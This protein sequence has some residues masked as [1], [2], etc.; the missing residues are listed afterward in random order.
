MGRGGIEK[1][2]K[3]LTDYLPATFTHPD[4]TMEDSNM[5]SFLCGVLQV[6]LEF[7]NSSGPFKEYAP[8]FMK[9]YRCVQDE[10]AYMLSETVSLLNHIRS[11]QYLPNINTIEKMDELQKLNTDLIEILDGYFSTN[12]WRLDTLEN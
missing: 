2:L 6:Y 9:P 4:K 1:V 7:W 11:C 8:D 12:I 5:L 10:C 3:Y